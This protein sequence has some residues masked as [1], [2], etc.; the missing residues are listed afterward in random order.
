MLNLNLIPA[1]VETGDRMRI[2]IFVGLLVA[3]AAAIG[4]VVYM[5]Y[6]K[7]LKK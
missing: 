2:G 4:I 5:N 6:F 7:K 3:A 1:V